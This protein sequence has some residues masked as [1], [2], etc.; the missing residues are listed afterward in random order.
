MSKT[1][2]KGVKVGIPNIIEGWYEQ[3]IEGF[4]V[5]V[6]KKD[7]KQIVFEFQNFLL[8]TEKDLE[9]MLWLARRNML[10]HPYDAEIDAEFSLAFCT[11]IGIFNEMRRKL[12]VSC[13]SV[14]L[15]N[16]LKREIASLIFT[17]NT[18]D[19]LFTLNLTDKQLKEEMMKSLYRINHAE[20]EVRIQVMSYFK[21]DSKTTST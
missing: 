10:Q 20:V 14:D 1:T 19:H 4:K 13:L 6:K 2:R 3:T 15:L 8:I 9:S 11:T 17:F 12:D 21:E 7:T 18:L 16:H 5:K